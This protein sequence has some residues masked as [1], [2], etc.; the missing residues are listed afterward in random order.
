MSQSTKWKIW[1]HGAPIKCQKTHLFGD[2]NKFY[3]CWPQICNINNIRGGG[4]VLGQNSSIGMVA[5]NKLLYH[6]IATYLRQFGGKFE[7]FNFKN[8]EITGVRMALLNWKSMKCWHFLTFFS[9]VFDTIELYH[10]NCCFISLVKFL[11]VCQNQIQIIYGWI[12]SKLKLFSITPIFS[13][14]FQQKR[15]YDS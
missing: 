2:N 12:D 4:K 10:P 15:Q 5:P 11:E 13:L 3:D 9:L 1:V 6:I 14:F 8:R 7:D